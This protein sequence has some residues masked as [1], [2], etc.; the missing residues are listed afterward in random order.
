MIPAVL[1]TIIAS[2]CVTCLIIAIGL[3]ERVIKSSGNYPLTRHEINIIKRAGLYNRSNL[4][5]LQ[6]DVES[7]PSE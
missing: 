3:A 4:I 1:S 6:S 2:T 5:K 7:L